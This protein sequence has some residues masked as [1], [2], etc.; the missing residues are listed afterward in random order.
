[1]ELSVL[2]LQLAEIVLAKRRA[3][4]FPIRDV[5]SVELLDY[6]PLFGRGDVLVKLGRRSTDQLD[7]VIRERRYCPAGVRLNER[8]ECGL[9]AVALTVFANRARGHELTAAPA[10]VAAVQLLK[11]TRAV[12]ERVVGIAE[13]VVAPT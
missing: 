13:D 8:P 9:I 3:E 10:H 4:F 6:L 1:M 7:N 5:S 2:V 12:R 11:R